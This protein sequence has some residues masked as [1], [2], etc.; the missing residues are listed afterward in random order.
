[1]LVT[2][3]IA[4]CDSCGRQIAHDHSDSICSPCRRTS[5]ETTAR[6]QSL[7]IRNRSEV[8]AAF[9]SAGLYGVAEYLDAT[10]SDALDAMFNSRLLP[11]ISERRRVL[12]RQL[13]G[14]KD[15]SHVAVARALHISRWTVATYR[16]QLGIDRVPGATRGSNRRDR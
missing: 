4:L 10:P 11:F 6:R 15:S 8:K 1:M 3:T 5:I 7:L 2:S 16:H 13:V 9:D 14:L 12:L